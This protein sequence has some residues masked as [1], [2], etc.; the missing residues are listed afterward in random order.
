MR[1]LKEIIVGSILACAIVPQSVAQDTVRKAIMLPE[2]QIIQL[3][4]HPE[5]TLTQTPTQVATAEKIERLGDAQLSDVLRR[6]VG[7]TLK[8]YGGI[9][10]IKTVSARGLGSQFSTLTIDGVAVTDCQNGQVDLGRYLLGNSSYISMSNGQVDNTLGSARAYSAGSIINMETHE[11]EFGA[12]PYN[13]KIG[14]EAGS[15]WLLSPT[16]SVERQLGQRLSVSAWANYLHTK[17]DYPFTLFYRPGQTGNTTRERRQNSQVDLATADANLFY[18]MDSRN[19]LHVKVHYMQGYH[20]LPGPVI[21]YSRLGTEHSQE[22]LFFAQA[23][24]RHTGRN[25]DWQ[26]LGKHQ[27]SKD[28]YEDTAAMNVGLVHNEYNQ[29]ESYLSQ[30]VRYHTGAEGKDYFSLTLS[31]DE[32]VNNL[33]S[34]LDNHNQVERL[35]ALGVVSAE[36]VAHKAKSLKG[37]RISGHLLGTWIRDYEPQTTSEPYARLSPYAGVTWPIGNFTLRY[38]YKEH[39]RVPNFNELYY[40]TIGHDL[41]PERARQHNLGVTYRSRPIQKKELVGAGTATVDLYYNRVNDK[42]VAIPMQN[43]YLWSMMNMG[44][45]EIE[46][47]DVTVNGCIE[48]RDIPRWRIDL[49]VGYSYQYAVDRTDTESKTYGH[50]IPYT[51]RHSGNI[52]LTATTPWVDVG[53]S[54]MM[55]GQRYALQQN[56]SANRVAGYTD[57]GISVSREFDLGESTIRVKAQVLNIFNKQYEVVKSYPMMGRNYRIGIVWQL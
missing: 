23:R 20:A 30:S 48:N 52:T 8:D 44:K 28:I 16:L 19:R 50:Q 55:V 15:F 37:M 29:S 11:P 31:A 33:R 12:R 13:L 24:H 5:G 32:A 56:T 43:M 54:A 3:N 6:M 41:R 25:W 17:G 53:Y 2:V 47:V 46:G 49:S 10:G 40:Y 36:Y 27:R 9:G 42:I 45:V 35:S 4:T 7:V 21:Y 38:F 14:G 1:R 39:F 18:R 51:P 34:N 26:L 57:H 22:Q